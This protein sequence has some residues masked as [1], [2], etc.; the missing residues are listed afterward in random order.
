M[1]SSLP[2]QGADSLMD[3]PNRRWLVPQ[4]I[5]PNETLSCILTFVSP[6][7]VLHFGQTCQHYNILSRD[8]HIW[9]MLA[10]R[11][12]NY[13]F[14]KFILVMDKCSHQRH[15]RD[16]L[17]SRTHILSSFF[18]LLR[19][20]FTS[21]EHSLVN[22]RSTS[23]VLNEYTYNLLSDIEDAVH[24]YGC[25]IDTLHKNT[26]S[27]P[28]HLYYDIM[29]DLTYSKTCIHPRTTRISSQKPVKLCDA[30]TPRKSNYCIECDRRMKVSTCKHNPFSGYCVTDTRKIPSILD[31]IH[32]DKK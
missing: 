16:V 29:D 25:L 14:D 26:F 11:D 32:M 22:I 10:Y 31:P 21:F 15:F 7:D 18:D 2:N 8:P 27:Y 12:F 5:L 17:S 19:Q 3:L 9:A 24:T 13:P 6:E 1:L 28:H 20:D 30:P 23:S 4:G